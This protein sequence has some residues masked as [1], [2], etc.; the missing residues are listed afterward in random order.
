MIRIIPF[1]RRFVRERG[2]ESSEPFGQ[3]IDLPEFTERQMEQSVDARFGEMHHLGDAFLCQV[4]VEFAVEHETES[5][6]KESEKYR[7]HFSFLE[8]FDR[9]VIVPAVMQL[10]NCR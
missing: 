10:K 5:S 7:E 9:F 6:W 3:L 8:F 2:D 4:K 1:I